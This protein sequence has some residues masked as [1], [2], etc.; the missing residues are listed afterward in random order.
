MVWKLLVDWI[1]KSKEIFSKWNYFPSLAVKCKGLIKL[2]IQNI[3]MF[4]SLLSRKHLISVD[5][6][7]DYNDGLT[8]FLFVLFNCL[9]VMFSSIIGVL[10]MI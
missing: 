10:L 8:L 4:K 7:I 5:G 9:S 1:D 6:V 3:L 2:V